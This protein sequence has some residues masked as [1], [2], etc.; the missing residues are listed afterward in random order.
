[1]SHKCPS[2]KIHIKSYKTQKGVTVKAHCKTDLGKRGKGTK[3]FTVKKGDLTKFC[4]SLKINNDMRRN[5]LKKAIKKIDKNTLIRKLN[6]LA[7]LHK[8]TNPIY[9]KRAKK[10]L[11]FIQSL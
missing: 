9:S 6:V 11:K 3:L 2:G 7:I 8:N 10:D 5:A 4:Y 1:M